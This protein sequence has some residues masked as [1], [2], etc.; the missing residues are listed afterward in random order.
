MMNFSQFLLRFWNKIINTMRETYNK[1]KTVS[2]LASKCPNAISPFA[3]EM[4][5]ISSSSGNRQIIK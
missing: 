2:F 5:N 3:R 4:M 1:E